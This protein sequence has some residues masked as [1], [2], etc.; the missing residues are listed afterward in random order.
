MDGNRADMV[1]TDPPYGVDY[2]GIHNDSR[3]GL[4]DLLGQAF[5]N[6]FLIMNDGAPIYVFH[7]DKCADIFHEEFRKRFHFSSIAI[8]VKPSLVMGQSDYQS[9]HEPIIYGWKEG[10][11]HAWESDRKQTSVWEFGRESYS[12]HTTPKPVELVSYAINNSS[13]QNK[14]VVDLFGGS[15][16]TIIACEAT[17]RKCYSMELDP[18]YCDLIVSRWCKYTGTKKII[19]NDSEIEWN[20]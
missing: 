16:S 5:D 10:S 2:D 20:G 3:S 17:K 13:K 6:Y 7:S 11:K 14:N 8:W 18:K 9:R 12:G 4:S 19:L 15:G 1:F